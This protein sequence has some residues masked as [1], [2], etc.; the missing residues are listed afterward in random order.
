[1]SL[2]TE[3]VASGFAALSEETATYLYFVLVLSRLGLDLQVR[4]YSA[5]ALT[6]IGERRT[7][8]ILV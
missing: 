8:T 3:A 6:L 5:P 2:R 1:M 4:Q 7:E